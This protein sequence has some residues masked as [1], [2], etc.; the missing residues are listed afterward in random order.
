MQTLVF[1]SGGKKVVVYLDDIVLYG[2]T[3]SEVWESTLK[4]L[5]EITRADFMINISK[6]S[7]LSSTVEA[8]GYKVCRG[9]Y[10]A[11]E[12]S[13]ARLMTVKLPATY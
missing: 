10:F 13:I 7:F 9:L 12:K 8:V 5:R 1:R 6:C 11:R 3:L 2:K 4:V